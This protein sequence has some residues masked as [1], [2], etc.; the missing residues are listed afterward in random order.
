MRAALQLWPKSK[1]NSCGTN[2]RYYQLSPIIFMF[3][4]PPA[5]VAA[6]WRTLFR[7]A[8]IENRYVRNVVWVM[9]LWYTHGRL[10][11]GLTLSAISQL[12]L[13]LE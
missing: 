13:E 7:Q 8:P 10:R 9:K 12:V 3:Y 2:S 6:D 11:K 4:W 5:K 1:I